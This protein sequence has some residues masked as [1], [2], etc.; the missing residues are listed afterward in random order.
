MFPLNLQL[1]PTHITNIAVIINGCMW[2]VYLIQLSHVTIHKDIFQ[3]VNLI[4]S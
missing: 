3:F 1:T 4:N 2:N